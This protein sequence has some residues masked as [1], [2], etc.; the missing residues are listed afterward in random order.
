MSLAIDLATVCDVWGEN[1]TNGYH[2]A[3]FSV[4]VA[5]ACHFVAT[6]HPLLSHPIGVL[7]VLAML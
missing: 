7:V 3:V 5:F 1:G 2:L 6:H 4:D